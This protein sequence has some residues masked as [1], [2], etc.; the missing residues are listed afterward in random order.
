MTS[1]SEAS[2]SADVIVRGRVSKLV[3]GLSGTQTDFSVSDSIKG[4]SRSSISVVQ[5]ALIVP[6][7]DWS[8]PRIAE[9]DAGPMLLPGDE[10]VLM[11]QATP[12][13]TFIIQSYTGW[14][15]VSGGRVAPS[16]KSPFG[17]T[18][19]DTSPDSFVSLIRASAGQ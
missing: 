19:M 15:R 16:S 13:G 7:P 14:Y 11:L 18:L 8:S 2:R 17:G 1:L 9:S 5:S 4:G 10:A 3:P 12:Q 6:G